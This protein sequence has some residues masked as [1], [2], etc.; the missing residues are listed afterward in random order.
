MRPS[1]KLRL[2]AATMVGVLLA[3]DASADELPIKVKTVSG[4]R[5]D[6]WRA[7]ADGDGKS[8]R[9]WGIVRKPRRFVGIV[10]GHLHVV[11]TRSNGQSDIVADT[12]WAPTADLMNFSV[13]LPIADASSVTSIT[14]SYA[15]KADVVDTQSGSNK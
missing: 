12:R 11:A 1:R 9:V 4:P 14:V 3:T 5:I 2:M 13:R 15:A 7:H 10:T 6:V 8:V